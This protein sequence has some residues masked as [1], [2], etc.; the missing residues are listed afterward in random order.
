M[1]VPPGRHWADGGWD[2]SGSQP[3]TELPS[4]ER[5][6]ARLYL[7]GGRVMIIDIDPR[8]MVGFRK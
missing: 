8:P 5:A 6:T 2:A 1:S 7:P 4:S 3:N